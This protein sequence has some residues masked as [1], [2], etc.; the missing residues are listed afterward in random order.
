MNINQFRDSIHFFNDMFDKSANPQEMWSK[1]TRAN[2][3]K[4]SRKNSIWKLT[5]KLLDENER[6]IVII[7]ASPCL[8]RDIKYL[9]TLSKKR[10]LTIAVNSALKYLLK[11][12]IKPDYVIA[13]DGS[14]DTLIRDLDCDNKDLTLLTSNATCPEAL[15]MWKGDMYW[16]AYYGIDKE[17]KPKVRSR[18]GTATP[19]GGNT[20]TTAL[21]VAYYVFNARMFVFVANESCYDEEYYVGGLSCKWQNRELMHFRAKDVK[22]RLRYT[23]LPL[24]QYKM[25]MENAIDQ[26]LD[27]IF[28][29]TSFGIVGTDCDNISHMSLPK[30]IRHVNEAFATRNRIL[31]TKDWQTR[32]KLRYE[33]AYATK[34]YI[35]TIGMKLFENITKGMKKKNTFEFKNIKRVLDVGCGMGQVV[36][37]MR[38]EGIEAYGCDIAGKNILPYWDMANVTQFCKTACADVLPYPDNHFGLVWCTDVLEHVPEEGV[39]TVLKEMHRVGNHDFLFTISLTK[40]VNP[41][42]SDGSNP[43]ATVK[44]VSWWIDK[45]ESNGYKIVLT[46]VSQE[47]NELVC[48]MTKG[49]DNDGRKLRINDMHL[50]PKRKM[51]K[52]L[53]KSSVFR[54]LEFS[55]STDKSIP[56]V[57][58]L[59]E[60]T[61]EARM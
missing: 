6:A 19:C 47:Q 10:F 5:G 2:L 39:D 26:L 33:A 50:L 36:A 34:Q 22:G 3:P 4:F 60:S 54:G 16:M 43:H 13:I 25:W 44:P 21:G 59:G 45:L 9:K 15:D 23:N 32:E 20:Y 51:Q 40:A 48:L 56:P 37:M 38:N 24:W 27:C 58:R 8:E 53:N 30:A 61:R 46:L 7:G 28:I 14:P 12:N 49:R 55:T 42:P 31:E 18:L 29:D 35:A 17:L 57:Q 52:V 1:N 41:M 11:E